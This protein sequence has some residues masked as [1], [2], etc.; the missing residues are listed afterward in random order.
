MSKALCIET[1]Y[2]PPLR[3]WSKWMDRPVVY[4]EAHEHYLKG[5]YRNRCYLAGSHGPLCLSIPL[6]KGKNEGQPIREVRIDNSRAWHRQ[7]WQSIRSC[8]GKA[9]FF[10]HYASALEVFYQKPPTFLFDWNYSLLL[11]LKQ[12]LNITPP[13]KLTQNYHHQLP[14][15][16][17]DWRNAISPK[18][19]RSRP[20]SSFNPRPYPQLF[21]D[22]LGFL[23][24]LSA[25]DLLM[26]MGPESS[27][28]L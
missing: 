7:H 4:I 14:E 6:L 12:Q 27:G 9:P 22:R 2:L 26:C 15:D 28:Y 5:S 24:N 3:Y 20:D 18:P 25:L 17:E 13:L 21:E 10:E 11:W 1:A 23:P 8:Y 19:H 16:V